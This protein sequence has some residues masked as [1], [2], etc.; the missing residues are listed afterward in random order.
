MIRIEK[1]KDLIKV[2]AAVEERLFARD[3]HSS[4]DTKQIFDFLGE[5]GYNVRNMEILQDSFCSTT[6]N[7]PPLSGTWIFRE[8]KEEKDVK[9]TK[10][11]KSRTRTRKS[12]T[13]RAAKEN[14][15]LGNENV[16]GVQSQTQTSV[17]RQDK[18]VS[19]E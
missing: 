10:N 4:I 16:D 7:N 17:H 14:K 2:F 6:G 18:K 11:T 9:T 1:E 19:G 13:T 5:S 15:L 3:P 12:R 8:K